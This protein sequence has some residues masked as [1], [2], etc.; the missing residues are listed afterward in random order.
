MVGCATTVGTWETGTR[1]DSEPL[2]LV[3]AY[4]MRMIPGVPAWSRVWPT[5]RLGSGK[6][7]SGRPYGVGTTTMLVATR[8]TVTNGLSTGITEST[9]GSVVS[10]GPR[11]TL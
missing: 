9:G 1:P 10:W 4:A 11:T 2:L 6:V 8:T 5:S 3:T 7:W